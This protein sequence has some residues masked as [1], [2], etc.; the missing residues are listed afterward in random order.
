MKRI[1]LSL[2]LGVIM[3]AGVGL[4]SG[5]G[6]ASAH[7]PGAHNAG[8][9]V[10]DAETEGINNAAFAGAFAPVGSHLRAPDAPGEPGEENGLENPN[11]S[12]LDGLANNPLCPLNEGYH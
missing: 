1:V 6:V 12:A 5:I 4:A 9:Y 2:A 8:E 10:G 7:G 3:F 11:S